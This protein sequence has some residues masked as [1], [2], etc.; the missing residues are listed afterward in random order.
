MTVETLELWKEQVQ[1]APPPGHEADV[2]SPFEHTS[3]HA[4][5][6]CDPTLHSAE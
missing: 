3:M 1:A 2:R 5:E 6:P 4:H